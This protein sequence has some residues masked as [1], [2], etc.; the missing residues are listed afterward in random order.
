M[1]LADLD[2]LR[3]VWKVAVHTIDAFDDDEN[4]A[5]SRTQFRKRLVE[6]VE[7]VMGKRS[8]TTT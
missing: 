1:F 3:Q 8:T 6:R 5:I 2:E 7:V 4:S